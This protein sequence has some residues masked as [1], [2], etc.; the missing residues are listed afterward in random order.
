M[1]RWQRVHR[2][3]FARL[4]VAR[5]AL[6]PLVCRQDQVELA[7]GV[8]DVLVER[9]FPGFGQRRA[10]LRRTFQAAVAIKW[11]EDAVRA[12]VLLADLGRIVEVAAVKGVHL[13]AVAL[14]PALDVT[15]LV[16]A[17]GFGTAI[18]VDPGRPEVGGDAWHNFPRFV[19]K[20]A[21]GVVEGF[22]ETRE[23]LAQPPA[24]CGPGLPVP[25]CLAII[26]DQNRQ[27]A[28]TGA[29]RRQHRA[30]RDRR[31][32]AYVLPRPASTNVV[33]SHACEHPFFDSV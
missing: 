22:V 2:S 25:R 7:M 24:T 3:L 31:A 30:A 11:R 1:K 32:M 29:I 9:Q 4:P 15:V 20:Y 19:V 14:Q 10:W 17:P 6:E 13:D 8:I 27:D 26:M 16:D 21:Q 18:P 5:A 33:S 23:T 12:A 28:A